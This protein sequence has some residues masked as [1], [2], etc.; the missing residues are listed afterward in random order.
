LNGRRRVFQRTAY[1]H[2][3]DLV[4]VGLTDRI[5]IHPCPQFTEDSSTGC[6]D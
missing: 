3:D 4:E 6:I 1:F 5:F 2:L